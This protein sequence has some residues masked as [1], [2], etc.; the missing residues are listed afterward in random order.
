MLRDT[1]QSVLKE[2]ARLFGQVIGINTYEWEDF[3]CVYN[4]EIVFSE[5]EICYVIDNLNA[6][7]D[8][9]GSKAQVGQEI[10]A[11]NRWLD[12]C[13]FRTID[14]EKTCTN[15][16]PAIN[17]KSW[18]MGYRDTERKVR[19]ADIVAKIETLKSVREQLVTENITDAINDLE[20]VLQDD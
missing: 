5:Y 20:F 8:K 2:Y 14:R 11:W 13:K 6:L 18:L 7:I 12:G 15:V 10:M 17:L 9:Y 1:L 19:Q 16:I 3:L 4:G